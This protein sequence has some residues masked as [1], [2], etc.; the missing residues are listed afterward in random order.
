M[1]IGI[2]NAYHFDPT[3]GNYQ[4][5]YTRLVDSFVR[6]TFPKDT[7][8]LF[9]IAL[10]N[11]PDSNSQCDVWFITGSAKSAYDLDPWIGK[12]KSK[13]QELNKEKQKLIGICFGHQIIAEALG[14][15]V[16]KSPK[17]WGVG[18]KDFAVTS[19]Q[20]WM[21]PQKVNLS[22]LFSHQDQVT[23][24]PPGAKLLAEDSFCKF[25]MFQIENHILAFQG[26]P[27]FS[28]DFAK[29]RLN[30]RQALMPPETFQ[31]ALKSY[32]KPTDSELFSA[33]LRQFVKAKGSF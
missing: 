8:Q 31:S 27:E 20:S 12:L 28:V 24:L 2:L 21:V 33:W 19:Q 32:S 30:S 15:K 17:G 9:D 14:G 3:P 10:G 11:W 18:I 1:K 26:H 4:E 22:L 16:I 6:R 23:E 7:V 29:A 13:I 25:Q 5:D